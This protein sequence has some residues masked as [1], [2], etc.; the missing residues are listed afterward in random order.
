MAFK[1][2]ARTLLELGK[3]LISTDE[4]AI[5]EL[6]KNGVD[7]GSPRIEIVA[8]VVI[9][10][11]AYVVATEALAA[12][13]PHSVVVDQLR[14]AVIHQDGDLVERFFDRLAPTKAPL[15]FSRALRSAYRRFNWLEVRDKGHGMSL[16]D[17][18]EVFLTIG[19]RSRRADNVRGAHYL[20][21]KGVGRLSTMRLGDRLSVT[22]TKAG[23]TH[24]NRLKIDWSKFTHENETPL[25]L[26]PVTPFSGQPKEDA[27]EQ[28]TRIRVSELAADWHVDRFREVFLGRIA[29]MVDPFEPGRGN[30]LLHVR[31]NGA[32][33]IVPSVPQELLGAA[34]ATC[35]VTF[36][37]DDETGDPVL[38]GM[39]EYKH[40][41]KDRAVAQRG[42]EVYSITQNV[43]KRRGKR[44]HA[45]TMAEPIRPEALRAL[46]PFRV[47]VYWY[48]RRIVEGIAKL[49]EKA[50]ETRQA[51]DQWS[52]GPMLYRR[53]FRI[54]PYG[55]PDDDWLALDRNAFG[56]SGF[57]LNRRQVIGRVNVES[58]HTALSEQTNREGLVQSEAADALRTI[59]KWLLHSELRQL[60]NDVDAENRLNRRKTERMAMSFRESQKLV[61][62]A[63]ARLQER[64]DADQRALVRVLGERVALMADQCAALVAD[65]DK[66]V[67]EVVDE[68]EKFVHLAGIGLMTEFIFHELERSVGHAMRAIAGA[69]GGSTASLSALAD[70]LATLQKR[71]SAFD[72][73]TGEKRQSKSTF[74]LA[75]VVA[76]VLE[77]HRS[78]FARHG[79]KAHFEPPPQPVRIKAVRGM[80]IQILENLLTNSTYWLKQQARYE[81]IFEPQIWIEID[82]GDLALTIEDNGPGVDPARRD[83]IFEPFISSKPTGQGRGLGLY[84]SREL[85]QYHGWQLYLDQEAGRQRRGR[86]NMFVLDMSVA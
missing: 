61:E 15:R 42:V 26:I 5:Y 75:D 34:H 79:I 17:L 65:T 27:E 86:L 25:D 10:H 14:A 55:D 74:D 31:H 68:R 48:N 45:E 18:S 49:T 78:E 44:G 57:K 67:K 29:R 73:F 66:A 35:D 82:P 28:G 20:G 70:Q 16:Q 63:L 41:G 69:Q 84:I 71:I 24:W 81:G 72:E 37:F 9:P 64:V 47:Q 3:E 56:Q 11:S 36:S 2:A 50:S 53:G 85:A 46:G 30:E 22:T 80:V 38:A 39:L 32:R 54:L 77:N 12:G 21:D 1:F 52:G 58:A 60:I 8:Q 76:I 40:F 19:T 23:E 4:V 33:L 7:A 51:I 59:V 43:W 83:V 62:D 13:K 6:I